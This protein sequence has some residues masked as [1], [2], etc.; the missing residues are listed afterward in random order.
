M[1]KR[2]SP[3]R[4]ATAGLRRIPS[5]AWRRSDGSKRPVADLA[6]GAEGV[7]LP[8][9]RAAVQQSYSITSS[10]RAKSA[11]GM[12]SPSSFAVFR[13]ITSCNFTMR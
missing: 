11:C 12:V 7:D 6:A 10:A 5:F 3:D 4:R 1:V 9:W 8:A 13:L 2:P